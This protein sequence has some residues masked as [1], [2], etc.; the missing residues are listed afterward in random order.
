MAIEVAEE[1]RLGSSE[2]VRPNYL[3][4]RE[5]EAKVTLQKKGILPLPVL[6]A[7]QRLQAEIAQGL[8]AFRPRTF[9]LGL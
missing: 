7:L 8:T 9:R 4:A 3:I 5:I 2:R 1:V 6:Q